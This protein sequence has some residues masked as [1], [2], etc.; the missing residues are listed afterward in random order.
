MAS[1]K[2]ETSQDRNATKQIRHQSQSQKVLF[3]VGTF[4]TAQHKLS[5]AFQ[6]DMHN[7]ITQIQ[8]NKTCHAIQ[9]HIQTYPGD[10]YAYIS[11]VTVMGPEVNTEN[12]CRHL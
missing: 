4:L 8:H 3:K 6:T 5:R 7:T 2:E 1:V 10:M 11:V 9:I 12:R